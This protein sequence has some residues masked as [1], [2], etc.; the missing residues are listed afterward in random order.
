MFWSQK[1][2]CSGLLGVAYAFEKQRTGDGDRFC[3]HV[4]KTRY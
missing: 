4:I 3:G 2:M 1:Q